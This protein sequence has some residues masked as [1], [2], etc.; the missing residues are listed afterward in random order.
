MAVPADEL[1]RRA[2]TEPAP[3]VGADASLSA[4][5]L[6]GFRAATELIGHFVELVALESRA[7]GTA[8]ATAV[9][10]GIGIVVLALTVWGLLV[11]AA[12]TGLAP[13]TGVA[14]ALLIVAGVNLVIG[15]LLALF[16]PKTLWRLSF[17]STRR[18][19]RRGDK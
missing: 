17:P 3:Q 6:T 15:G 9:G 7:A 4:L 14:V 18:M 16:L 12:V 5:A 10:L 1:T 8:L 13:Y 2:R 19:F 11:A